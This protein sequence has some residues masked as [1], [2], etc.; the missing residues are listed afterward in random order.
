MTPLITNF[1]KEPYFN[2]YNPNDNYYRVLSKAGKPIQARELHEMQSILNNQIEVFGS[3]IYNNGDLLSGGEYTVTLNAAYVRLSSITQG[4]RAEDF[5]GSTVRGVV[6][7]VVA[8]VQYAEERDDTSDFVFYV[9]YISSGVDSEFD[10]FVEG[11]TLESSTDNNYTATVG[12]GGTSKPIDTDPLGFGSLFTIEEGYMYVNGFAV[13]V[14]KQTISLCK[15]SSRPSFQVGLIVEEDI[16]TSNEDETLLDNAQGYSNFAAPGADRLKISLILS[17]RTAE[18][19]EANFVTL[20]TLIQGNIIGNP[21]QSRKWEWLSDLLAQRTYE[22]SGNYIV[23]DFPVTKLEY[24]NSLTDVDQAR[25]PLI[26]DEAIDGVFDPDPELY[27]IEKPYPPVPQYDSTGAPIFEFTSG[28]TG[29]SPDDLGIGQPLTFEEANENYALKL[30]PGVGYIQGYRVGFLNHLYVYGKKPRTKFFKPDTYTQ[31]NSG[32]F[33]LV[34]NTYNTPNISNID[35]VLKTRAFDNITCYRNFTDGHVGS[36][37]TLEDTGDSGSRGE[38]RPLNLGNKPWITYHII[39]NKNV[40]ITY[41][42]AEDSKEIE[43]QTANNSFFATLVYPDRSVDNKVYDGYLRN[44]PAAQDIITTEDGDRLLAEGSLVTEEIS[45]NSIVVAVEDYQKIIR[46]DAI[47][48]GQQ[49]GDSEPARAL[50]SQRIEPIKS[51][52]LQPKYYYPETTIN[53]KTGLVGFNSSYNLGV[54]NSSYYTEL[55]VIN[56]PTTA[57]EEWVVGNVV[58]GATSNAYAKIEQVL[59]NVLVVS[60]LFGSFI[61]GENIMM[62]TGITNDSIETTDALL[63]DPLGFDIFM[64]GVGQFAGQDGFRLLLDTFLKFR[65]RFKVG[66]L[67][68][69][70]EV[71]ALK[72]NDRF[73]GREAGELGGGGGDRELADDIFGTIVTDF[74]QITPKD[75]YTD[76]VLLTNPRTG[77]RNTRTPQEEYGF[78]TQEDYNLWI[79]NA[80]HDLSEGK[81][82]NNTFMSETAPVEADVYVGDIWINKS[83]YVVY[84]RDLITYDDGSTAELW[85]AVTPGQSDP[86]IPPAVLTLA[87]DLEEARVFAEE[88]AATRDSFDL[89]RERCIVVYSTGTTTTLYGNGSPFNDNE[90]DPITNSKYE[91]FFYDGSVNELKL[92]NYGRKKIYKFAFFDP[93]RTSVL[94]RVNYELLSV[95]IDFEGRLTGAGLRG[96]ATSSPAKTKSSLVKTKSFHSLGYSDSDVYPDS[97]SADANIVSADSSEIYDIANGALF[98]GQAGRNFVTCDNFSGDASEDLIAG[99]VVAFADSRGRFSYKLVA[100]VTKP[101]GYGG[102]RTKCSVYF[103]TTLETFVSSA[104]MQR[105]RLRSF[106]SSTESLIYPLPVSTVSSL[107]TNYNVTGINYDVFREYVTEKV[108]Q[109]GGDSLSITFTTDQSNATFISDAKRCVL[110]IANYSA[111]TPE[112]DAFKG[113]QITLDEVVPMEISDNGRDIKLNLDKSIPAEA[114][115]GAQIKAILPVRITNAKAKRK[116]LMR[117]FVLT[118]PPE[119]AESYKI[120][121]LTKTDVYRLIKVEALTDDP[122]VYVDVTDRYTFDNGQRDTIYDYGRIITKPGFMAEARELKITFDYFEHESGDGRDFFS[123]DSYTHDDGIPYDDIPVYLP[124]ENVPTLSSNFENQNEYTKLRDV[125]DFRPVI[126]SKDKTNNT[127]DF[128][129]DLYTDFSTPTDKLY[130]FYG[131]DVG[132]NAFVPDIPIPTT[133]FESDIEYYLPKIDSLFLDKTGKMVLKEGEPSDNP[134]RPADLA[135]GVR[136]YDIFMPAYTFSMDDVTIKKYNY[137]RYTMKDITSLDKRIERVENLVT[138]SILEQSALNVSV[139]DAITGLDR[140]K[141]GIIVDSF[142]DHSRGDVGVEQYRCAIDPKETHL[143]SPFV[144]DQIELEEEN[145]TNLDRETFGS[146]RMS[147]NIVTVDYDVVDYIKQPVATRSVDVQKYT[148]PVF[149][150]QITL[151]PSMDTFFD[152]SKT[153]KLMIDNSDVYSATLSLTDSQR[154]TSLAT[155]WGDWETI[156]DIPNDRVNNFGK[157]RTNK[158]LYK[159]EDSNVYYTPGKIDIA[160]NTLAVNKARNYSRLGHKS[161]TVT[162]QDTSYGKRLFDVQLSHTMRSIPVFFKA[163]RLKPNTRYFAFFDDVKVDDW[164]CV[165]KITEDF[166]DGLKRYNGAPNSEPLGFGNP[167]ISDDEGNITGV[168]IIPNGRSPVKDSLFTGRMEDVVYNTSGKSRSF[169]TGERSLKFSSNASVD[170]NATDITG[171][172]KT[173]F[174]SR[175]V[176]ADKSENIVSTRNIEHTT[177]TT[178]SEESRLKYTGN[179]NSDFDPRVAPSPA[180]TPYDPIAQTFI[181]D[182]NFADGVFVTELDLFFRSKDQFQGVETYIVTTEGGVPTNKIVPHS[183]VVKPTNTVLRIVC[184]LRQSINTTFIAAGTTILG[185]TSGATGIVRD[186]QEFSSVVTNPNRNVENTVYNLIISNYLGEFIPGEELEIQVNPKNLNTFEVAENEVTITRIDIQSFGENYD[187]NTT[188]EISAPDLPGGDNATAEVRVAKTPDNDFVEG[189]NGNVY[190]VVLTSSGNGYTRAPAVTISGTGTNATAKAIIKDGRRAVVMGV[191]TS[192]DA[193][194]ATKFKF[195]APVYLLGNKTYAFVVKSPTNKAYKLWSSKI[196]ENEIGTMKKVTRQPNMGVMFTAQNA[197]IWQ[198]DESMDIMFNLNR[199]KFDTNIVSTM[200]MNNKPYY[201]DKTDLNP[202]VTYYNAQRPN[203]Q[204]SN[205]FEQNRSVVR[206]RHYNHGLLPNDY[207]L[208]EGVAG[209]PG[210]LDND[211]INGLHQVIDA[212]LN[213]FT[214]MV[215]DAI[216]AI[217]TEMGGGNNVTVTRNKPFETINLCSGVMSFE[218]SSILA[219]SRTTQ[220]AGLPTVPVVTDTRD[221]YSVKLES[222]NEEGAYTLDLFEDIPILDSYY[223]SDTKQVAS[224]LNEVKHKDDNY[225]RGQKSL[226]TEFK[227]QTTDDRVSP[228]VDLDRTNMTI[229]HNMVDKPEKYN[230][231]FTTTALA[232]LQFA[233]NTS[234]AGIEVG[235]K[236]EFTTRT[237]KKVGL[238]IKEISYVAKII[239]VTG[240]EE[241]YELMNRATFTLNQLNGSVLDIQFSL[242]DEY[243]PE[244]VNDGNTYAKW[245]SRMFVLEDDCDGIEVK[246]SSVFYDFDD[247][248][249][250]YKTRNVGQDGDFSK[251]TWVPFNPR[252]V[253]PG[254]KRKIIRVSE[255]M[256]TPN[257]GTVNQNELMKTPGMADNIE[258]VKPRNPID[259]DPRRILSSEWQSLNFSVQD[260]PSFNAVA[261]KIVMSSASSARVPL[262]DDVSIICSI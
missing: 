109:S 49:G 137:R 72:F 101:F 180:T 95:N 130:N 223:Y 245:L 53:K 142:D 140:F 70:G 69:D 114:L 79:Y 217:R 163:E 78:E 168:F 174:L 173:E 76:D 4:S 202:I 256:L 190:E 18:T 170:V 59:P 258:S 7:G 222:V 106:G 220:Y 159:V 204:E 139:R 179:S 119:V 71:I 252:S 254:E 14:E 50:I 134:V 226:I 30:D 144:I 132:G 150:G 165:D 120:I 241:V 188:V 67:I 117:D 36:A 224:Y 230:Q 60:N 250:Y 136:L 259:V 260:L 196:G 44:D 10:T 189:I 39:L 52:N 82:A 73:G 21:T 28:C 32:S 51:G 129:G 172:A 42:I 9:N 77:N 240:M 193:T 238:T 151:M 96:Y 48:G 147:N 157:E 19:E 2:D 55:V 24:W 17:K 43:I 65:S 13:R 181:V 104:V 227:L 12:V 128:S 31:I 214:I 239:I 99:D 251:L 62:P 63:Q 118:V 15:Y 122:G 261:I 176:I 233:E 66:R 131:T 247:I 183:R 161:S 112:L 215:D 169:C 194:S 153:P 135:T 156:G 34:N 236:L 98:S 110:T 41:D 212:N 198:S 47:I 242:T 40:T 5:I 166:S 35:Y 6:S 23:K 86:N 22:E 11:E 61:P 85:I 29:K 3:N 177:N 88:N 97:F 216:G 249:V 192:D 92:T 160:S 20:V 143:R 253:K 185:K 206:V 200:R 1:N 182:K 54:M 8:E 26:D 158:K 127:G 56:D 164:I 84:V 33:V 103:T 138:L 221:E 16:I 125:V 184:T 155:V 116:F 102:K 64:D 89:S 141:N 93:D 58:I 207:V 237:N 27:S 178:L 57:Q 68:D 167:L 171:Y 246:L 90:I 133:Q 111:F 234:F 191:S 175:A 208:I 46:G 100:F 94:P 231:V 145:Q 201:S 199:A 121:S 37:F 124:Q 187:D 211:K 248:R 209:D 243:R 210:G 218:S 25:Y 148:S 197:G 81:D 225:M 91:D 228:V 154:K 126:N 186:D 235:D 80:I 123:V 257:L 229:C 152:T 255:N 146:Y 244:D 38:K 149:E 113:R 195:K 205:K 87:E 107:E 162:L 45:T 108:G 203:V 105:V 219:S 262:I 115:V 74:I 75:T 232:T 213:E 83:N